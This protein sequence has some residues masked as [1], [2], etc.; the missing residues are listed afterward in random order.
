MRTN[1]AP[2]CAASQASTADLRRQRD[3]RR[4]EV[5]AA[6]APIAERPAIHAVPAGEHLARSTSGTRGLTSSTGVPDSSGRSTAVSASPG[7]LPARRQAEQAGRHVAPELRRDRWRMRRIDA[8]TRTSAAATS[9]PASA[10]PP[11]IPKP[12]AAACRAAIAAP[13]STPAAA[14]QRTRRAKHEIVVVAESAANGPVISSDDPRRPAPRS[15][16]RHRCRRRT[17]SRSR[18]GRRAACR[19][20]G[21]RG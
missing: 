20:R 15:A 19:G 21:A 13:C 8:A 1:S 10:E 14:A 6:L 4:L 2:G 16:G 3:R 9:P 7:P 18:G 11:P 5:V 12:P 17:S